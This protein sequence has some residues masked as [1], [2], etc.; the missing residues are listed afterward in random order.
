MYTI[1]I[2]QLAFSDIRKGFRYYNDVQAGLGARFSLVIDQTLER[3]RKMPFAA[4]IAYDDVRYKV[5]DSFPYI[6]LY[7]IQGNQILIARV[8]N[9]YQ[10][11]LYKV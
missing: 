6:I 11:P 4:S 2:T 5:V 10:K 3:I 1:K 8:F 9:S 7:K